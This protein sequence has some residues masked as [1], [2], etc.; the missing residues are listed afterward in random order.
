[1]AGS[2]RTSCHFAMRLTFTVKNF[3][4]IKYRGLLQPK[5]RHIKFIQRESQKNL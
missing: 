5:S 4:I 1:M 2:F 3:I